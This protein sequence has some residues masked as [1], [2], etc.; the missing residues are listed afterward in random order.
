MSM[1][2]WKSAAHVVGRWLA[3][4]VVAALLGSIVQTQF[5]LQALVDLG[6]AIPLQ[7]RLQTT[8]LDLLRF[9]PAYAAIVA[10]SFALALPVAAWL[11]HRWPR[12][13]WLLLL[14]G[15]SA[16]VT[17]LVLM[18]LLLK[19]TAI[20]AARSLWGVFALALAGALGGWVFGRLGKRHKV[21]DA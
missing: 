9:T 11:L 3:A 2:G 17:A 1:I 5:N 18:Q 7:L 4:V 10:I 15:A 6:L 8:W 21:R 12:R 20:A 16:I 19:L 14:A 13:R